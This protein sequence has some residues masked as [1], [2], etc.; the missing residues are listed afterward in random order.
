[1]RLREYY[2]LAAVVVIVFLLYICNP[3]KA[4]GFESQTD[5][6]FHV[7]IATGGRPELRNMIDSLRDELE[8]GDALTIV[9]DGPTARSKCKMDSSWFNGFKAKVNLID[10]NPNL[11]F[12][13]H[14]IRN[15]YQ[16]K[17]TPKTTFVMHAD[18]DDSYYPGSFEKL[19]KICTDPDNLYITK[20]LSDKGEVIPRAN[21]RIERNNIGTPNGIV[22]FAISGSSRWEHK[23]GGDFDYY[24]GIKDHVKDVVHTNLLIYKVR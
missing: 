21:N 16:H 22:P 11:G 14:G 9:F 5:P 13:G 23:Y 4:E 12:W 15:E 2:I 3:V 17:L 7:L 19:R 6:T 8:N 24:N 20:M 10:Q 1:M 18:D